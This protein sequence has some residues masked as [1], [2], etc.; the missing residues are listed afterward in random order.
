VQRLSALVEFRRTRLFGGQPPSAW[1]RAVSDAL[2]LIGFPGERSL[3]STEFQTLAK[4]HE[5]VADFAALDRVVP[6]TGYGDA[7]SRLRRM[8]TDT[9]F[10]PETPVVPIQ[11][12]GELEATGMRFDHLWVMGLS[13]ETWPRG[14]RPNPF[15]P[16]ELQRTAGIPQ[17]SAAA[18]LELA[19]RLTGEW[20][21]CAGEVV[22]S[23]PRREDD[24]EFKPSP[25]IVA[26]PEQPLP[27]PDFASY[28][29]AVHDLRK[30]ERSEDAKAPPL[31]AAAAVSG[32]T[33]IIQDHA[34][35]PFRALARHRLGA[36]GLE[37]PHAG[38]DARER[39]TLVH[40]VLAQAWA[41][42]RTRSA[43][44]AISDADLDA[45]L[46]R[47]AADAIARIRRE[48]PTVLSGRFAEIEKRRLVRL[49]RAWLAMEKARGGFTVLAT[50]DKRPIQIGGL[51]L[52]ARLDRVDETD[53]GRRIVIDYKTGRV[54]PGAMLSD[55]P[56]EPQLPLYLVGAEPDAAAVAFAQVKAGEMRFAA[57]ARDDDLLPDTK[58]FSE[59]PYGKRYGSWQ[60]VVAAWR[61]DLTRIA[62]SFAGG[63][64]EVDPKR[65]PNTCRYCDVKP[66]C[67]IYERLENALDED[68]V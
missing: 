42:L 50:E 3:D 61:A 29:D 23:Y 2:T 16:V 13:D 39:G 25:L 14:P 28:R 37:A 15:L 4:W 67:R 18:S 31:G 33:A 55:R 53:D 66:F 22:L 19:R 64:A 62:A 36:E 43:L 40:R 20:L 11:I 38:L 12:L 44:D 32:G 56:E 1:A 5:V 7:V 59:S 17:G 26:V 27:L 52:N 60:D 41:Q 10:Q 49:G 65:Y 30:L 24:R 6:R 47:A 54:S 51:T 68:A 8:A 21:S 9:L 63:N 34:A 46:M 48:R 35:C 58:A 57:L 45:L